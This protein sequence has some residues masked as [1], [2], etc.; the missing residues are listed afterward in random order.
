MPVHGEGE[1]AATP[2]P[3]PPRVLRRRNSERSSRY[4]SPRCRAAAVAREPPVA[5]VREQALHHADR[6]V[7]RGDG[8]V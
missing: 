7:E 2:R 4:S 6:R 3:R 1:T 5:L 8:S